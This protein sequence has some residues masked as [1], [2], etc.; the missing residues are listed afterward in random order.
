VSGK[1]FNNCFLETKVLRSISKILDT[2]NI[3]VL[4]KKALSLHQQQVLFSSLFQQ[5]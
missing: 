3:E 5:L 4:F 1:L 2:L